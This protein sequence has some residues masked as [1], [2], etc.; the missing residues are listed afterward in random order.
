MPNYGR[1]LSAQPQSL[2]AGAT[3]TI[4]APAGHAFKF[5]PG[6]TFVTFKL[7]LVA[8]IT[9][10]PAGVRHNGGSEITV[11]FPQIG[12]GTYQCVIISGVDMAETEGPVI[13]S[14][15]APG[16]G[17]GDCGAVLNQPPAG[18]PGDFVTIVAVGASPFA[19]GPAGASVTF[20]GNLGTGSSGAI[21]QATLTSLDV[22]VLDAK[23]IRLALP[24]LPAGSYNVRVT[25][26]GRSAECAGPQVVLSGGPVAGTREATPISPSMLVPPGGATGVTRVT[27]MAPYSRRAQPAT[28]PSL[29]QGQPPIFV[30]M[31]QPSLL[32]KIWMGLATI[33]GSFKALIPATGARGKARLPAPP[34]Q[35]R[36]PTDSAKGAKPGA[37]E[38]V[39]APEAPA[40]IDPALLAPSHYRRGNAVEYLIDG[41]SFFQRASEIMEAVA[42][43]PGDQGYVHLSFWICDEQTQMEAA[44]KMLIDLVKALGTAR[45]EV[46]L[47]LW[48]PADARDEFVAGVKRVN[49]RCKQQI[50]AL[51][52]PSVEVQ[53]LAHPMPFGS[54]HQSLVIGGMAEQAE[55]LVG[56]L[57]PLKRYRD[58]APHAGNGWHDLAVQ[59]SGP[60]TLDLEAQWQ[61]KWAMT[62][63]GKARGPSKVADRGSD[64]VFVAATQPPKL[65]VREELIARIQSANDYVYMENHGIFDPA[66]VSALGERIKA[67]KDAGEP[68]RVILL[69]PHQ[70]LS[71]EHAW[72]HY[73]TFCHLSFMSCDSFSFDDAGTLRSVSRAMDG[74]MAW[75][76]DYAGDQFGLGSWH[77]GSTVSWDTGAVSVK[78]I[79]G[80]A[81]ETLLYTLEHCASAGPPNTFSHVQVHSKLAI[82]D[83]LFAA[84]GSAD[85]TPR[86]MQ[87]DAELTAFI[88]G[89]SV[90]AFRERLWSEYFAGAVPT[91]QEWWGAVRKNREAVAGGKLTLGQLYIM[92]LQFSVPQR[93][94]GA[95][96]PWLG[97][98]QR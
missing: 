71:T 58:S 69:L 48:L 31:V 12:A 87:Q 59:V 13:G 62:Q 10:V 56:G 40:P 79:R 60:A 3:L 26:G 83:D 94:P 7:G 6:V 74:P 68:F 49:E 76:F 29:G 43:L 28:L 89:D 57:N 25:S 78:Q 64:S 35:A 67:K 4:T 75:H 36:T 61:A 18:R 85:F 22:A 55:A 66:I 98:D 24:Q 82:I 88:H 34:R 45:K 2:P 90:K 23:G 96:A 46:K 51:A 32:T 5:A 9:V 50:D 97:A 84:V 80:F 41:E 39:A 15:M 86:G 14:G 44:G 53:L 21:Y 93:E 20:T 92:P 95:P 19:F 27:L 37:P 77:E 1:I 73:L 52:L 11:D 8:Q 91:P 72:L 65:A 63:G 33:P 70:A 81:G 38:G 17:A 54:Y 30:S 16:S 47:L 42:V